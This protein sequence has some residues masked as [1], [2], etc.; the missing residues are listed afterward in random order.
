MT[1]PIIRVVHENAHDREALERELANRYSGA[2]QIISDASPLSAL[3]RLQVLRAAGDTPV[4]IMFAPDA[5]AA[6]PGTQFLNELTGFIRTRNV[7]VSAADGTAVVAVR[8]RNYRL[9]LAAEGS[10]LVQA[11]SPTTR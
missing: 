4:F 10:A 7:S 3:E 2:Y 1:T 5:M 8:G 9:A 6:M 11:A